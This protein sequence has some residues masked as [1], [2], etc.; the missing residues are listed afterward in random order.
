MHYNEKLTTEYR[1]LSAKGVFCGSLRAN[2]YS[3]TG[4]TLEFT[5]AKHVSRPEAKTAITE[6]LKSQYEATELSFYGR[7]GEYNKGYVKFHSNCL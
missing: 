7:Q 3:D 5:W 4:W 1:T 2:M 6:F